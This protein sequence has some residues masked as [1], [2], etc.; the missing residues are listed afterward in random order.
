MVSGTNMRLADQA[1]H[2]GGAALAVLHA[3]QVFD[4]GDAQDVVQVAL[5]DRDTWCRGA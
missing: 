1:A 4:V 5:V 2:G 3:H